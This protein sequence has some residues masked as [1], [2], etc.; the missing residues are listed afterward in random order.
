[1]TP[2]LQDEE[3]ALAGGR[4]T[5]SVVRVGDTVRRPR[6]HSSDFVGR[7]L[8]HVRG[9]GF[10]QAPEYLGGDDQ[11]REVFRY[12]DGEVPAK[13][14]RFEDEQVCAAARMLREFHDATRGSELAGSCPVVCHNDPGPNNFV[15]QQS[16]PVAII[17]FDLAAPGD[18]LWDL[19]Y[20][21]WSWCVS[22]RP[23]RLPVAE[24]AAQVRLLLDAY[25]L[26]QRSGIVDAMIARQSWNIEFWSKR[27]PTRDD[28]IEWSRQERAFT[29]AHRAAFRV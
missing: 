22:S 1:M 21:A 18:A 29:Q 7:L 3:V 19:G 25:G 9:R 17:D 16:L 27:S 2:T 15:F 20:M 26:E 12:I 28:V 10:Q 5:P 14:R 13:F 11:E 24:Q 4:L 6:L 8:R 23:D